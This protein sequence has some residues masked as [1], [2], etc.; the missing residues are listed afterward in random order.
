MFNILM[1]CIKNYH[2]CSYFN[3]LPF[4]LYCRANNRFES[5]V[6]R[7]LLLKCRCKCFC[8]LCK[9][10]KFKR[11]R[12]NRFTSIF[13]ILFVLAE[14]PIMLLTI[15]WKLWT[16]NVARHSHDKYNKLNVFFYFR[17]VVWY[18]VWFFRFFSRRCACMTL[19]K[20]G[21]EYY[22]DRCILLKFQLRGSN[23]MLNSFIQV[24]IKL[25]ST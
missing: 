8:N 18:C 21:N 22:I 15:E 24:F 14:E 1:C 2:N 16:M 10:E 9:K 17:Y 20:L 11:E 5:K 12:E 25:I 4:T 6:Q 13:E 23:S 3:A 19:N 7:I